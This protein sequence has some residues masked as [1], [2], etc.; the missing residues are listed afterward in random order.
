LAKFDNLG[1][2]LVSLFAG[3]LLFSFFIFSFPLCYGYAKDSTDMMGE[4]SACC[5]I[6]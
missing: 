3:L 2:G 4:E 6:C 1:V 5:G